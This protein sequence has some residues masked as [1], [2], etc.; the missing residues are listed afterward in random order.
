[1]ADVIDHKIFGDDMQVVEIES[2]EAELFQQ[3]SFLHS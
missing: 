3:S 2:V 1:M